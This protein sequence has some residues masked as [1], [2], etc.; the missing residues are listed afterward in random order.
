MS[1]S[2]MVFYEKEYRIEWRDVCKQEVELCDTNC[3]AE[4]RFHRFPNIG[5]SR[6]VSSS[7]WRTRN[8]FLKN[9]SK[10]RV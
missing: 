4:T 9:F 2:F 10:L 8:A 3:Q 6:D 7:I 1:C 5:E